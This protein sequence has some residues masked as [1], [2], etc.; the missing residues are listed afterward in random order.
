MCPGGIHVQGLSSFSTT[1]GSSHSFPLV[2]AG[3]INVPG[4]HV[5]AKEWGPLRL[6]C[7][8]QG[9]I[10]GGWRS[11]Q[12]SLRVRIDVGNGFK[13]GRLSK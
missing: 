10:S 5:F 2:R 4:M 6:D 11:W 7:N 13:V 12:R 8:D 9:L 1:W 3:E